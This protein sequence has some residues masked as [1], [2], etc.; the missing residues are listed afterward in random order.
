MLHL[1]EIIISQP[2]ILSSLLR[3]FSSLWGGTISLQ[4]PSSSSSA[5]LESYSKSLEQTRTF[6]ASRPAKDTSPLVQ[7]DFSPHRPSSA[8]AVP[9]HKCKWILTFQIKSSPI[10]EV[11]T[12]PV[13]QPYRGLYLHSKCSLIIY[14]ESGDTTHTA[15]SLPALSCLFFPLQKAIRR[16]PW[17]I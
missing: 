14:E 3:G 17:V 7:N 15:V 13:G 6:T 16:C 11:M 4:G 2:A 1:T 8:T 5:P 10:A 9:F 12:N